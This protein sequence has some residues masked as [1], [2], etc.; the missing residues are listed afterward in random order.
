M[1]GEGCGRCWKCREGTGCIR[2]VSF[3]PTAM[4]TRYP[5]ATRIVD[6]DKQ[7]DRDMGAYKRI[8]ANGVQPPR[9]DDCAELESKA[10]DQFEIEEAKIVPKHLHST[11]K[12]GM[13]IAQAMEL[14]VSRPASVQ[15]PDES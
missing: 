1:S 14:Q 9:I 12:E 5:E 2:A 10:T 4:P 13:A 11:V 3:A 8:R 6:K 7:W 15:V